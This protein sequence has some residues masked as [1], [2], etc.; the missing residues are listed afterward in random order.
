ME[1]KPTQP[2]ETPD[3]EVT[4][5][6]RRRSFSAGY[7]LDILR[8]CLKG[9]VLTSIV[10][11]AA[12]AFGRFFLSQIT[13]ENS[14]SGPPGV[15]LAA[16]PEVRIEDLGEVTRAEGALRL[17][18]LLGP[19]G[20]KADVGVHFSTVDG[21]EFFWYAEKESGGLLVLV[22]RVSGPGST[23]LETRWREFLGTRLEWAQT[24]GTFDAPDL[25]TGE[26]KNL[27]H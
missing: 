16:P 22:E 8:Q 5:K 17:S 9:L 25:P 15:I 26:Q 2:L 3:P 10:L 18:Q 14:V 12:L 13:T 21:R 27:Y 6:A 19:S 20:E 1:P 4:P 23:R 24:H 7:K 11:L